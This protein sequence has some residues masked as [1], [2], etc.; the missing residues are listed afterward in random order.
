MIHNMKYLP[1]RDITWSFTQRTNLRE[2]SEQ[3][4]GES[5]LAGRT[6]KASNIQAAVVCIRRKLQREKVEAYLY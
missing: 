6:S 5:E 4:G 2:R 3:H 1:S